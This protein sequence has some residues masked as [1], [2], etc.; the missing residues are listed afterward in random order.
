MYKWNFFLQSLS[1]EIYKES[2]IKIKKNN[3]NHV[4]LRHVCENKE[5]TVTPTRLY[6]G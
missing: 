2:T 6:L 1:A 5:E 4:L 3:L